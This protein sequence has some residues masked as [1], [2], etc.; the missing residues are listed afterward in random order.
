MDKLREM[1]KHILLEIKSNDRLQLD[2]SQCALLLDVSEKSI[3]RY[4]KQIEAEQASEDQQSA[5]EQ[6]K[7]DINESK[8]D[9]SPKESL[10]NEREA[11]ATINTMVSSE[12][13]NNFQPAPTRT[14]SL[15]RSRR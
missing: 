12:D 3:Q 8:N 14:S 9:N 15:F 7:I 13:E 10:I 6:Q 2:V 11:E 4:L 5:N 1:R